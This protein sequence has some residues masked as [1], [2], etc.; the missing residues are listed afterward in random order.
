MQPDLFKDETSVAMFLRLTCLRQLEGG[1]RNCS[2]D[3][4]ADISSQDLF[5]Y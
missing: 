2:G 5:N 3:I 4:G 1:L